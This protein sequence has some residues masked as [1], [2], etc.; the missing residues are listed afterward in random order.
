MGAQENLEVVKAGYAAFNRDDI[1]GLLTLLA[2]D[3]EWHI[4]G[5]GLPLAGTYR[6]HDGV[7]K[8]FE[9]LT[10]DTEISDFEPREFKADGDRVLV[11]GW[12]RGK[13]KATNR[14]FELHW[15]MAFTV[16]DGEI[17]KFREYTD[18]QAIASAYE[19]A[20]TAAV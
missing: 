15:V 3:V 14:T 16:R 1:P 18:T 9:K 7:A 10:A 13:V 17:T 2:E 20:A 4:P 19:S 5:A 8:F 6:G 12:E 11:V